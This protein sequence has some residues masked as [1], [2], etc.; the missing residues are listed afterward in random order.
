MERLVDVAR[1]EVGVTDKNLLASLARR[2]EAEQPRDR[3]PEP[4]GARFAGTDGRIDGDARQLHKV[5]NS[6]GMWRYPVDMMARSP[7]RAVVGSR[8]PAPHGAKLRR[9][10]TGESS[11]RLPNAP[12]IRKPS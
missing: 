8:D 4:A 3:E 10:H 12:P 11:R 1:F 6:R 7:M 2:Q 5:R 9:T